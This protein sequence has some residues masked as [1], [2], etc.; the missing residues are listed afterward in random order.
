MAVNPYD[1]KRIG[2]NDLI[3]R[4]INP[5]QHLVW[6][7]NRNRKRI[8]TKAYQRSS[9]EA[10]GMSVDIEAL[11]VADRQDPKQFVTTP[12]FT[13]SVAFMANQIRELGLILGYDPIPDNPY[14]GQVWQK[15]TAKRFTRTQQKG[16]L[17]AAQWYVRLE[18]VDIK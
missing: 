11:I 1:E 6:D 2:A 5:D 10:G 14:H 15:G 4:R 17:R 3:I 7:D 18:G 8:S 12:K 16:L 9:G 13:G